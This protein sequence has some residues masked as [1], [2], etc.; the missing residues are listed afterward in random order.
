MDK[1]RFRRDMGGVIEA[2]Q[3]VARRLG[4][5]PENGI[6]E[7]GEPKEATM[8]EFPTQKKDGTRNEG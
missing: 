7:S 8:V 3:E 6:T 2:Y 1:D 4:I 5:L